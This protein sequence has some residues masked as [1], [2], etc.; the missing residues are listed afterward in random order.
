MALLVIQW[1]LSCSC[2][3]GKYQEEPAG[4][5]FRTRWLLKE[6]RDTGEE[7]VS[8]FMRKP[9]FCLC[10]QQKCRSDCMDASAQSDQHLCCSMLR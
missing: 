5:V 3:Y 10:E 6:A 9:A 8:L 4:I 1:V 2:S 7:Y